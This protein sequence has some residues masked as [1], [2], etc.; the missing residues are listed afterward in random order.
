MLVRHRCIVTIIQWSLIA[1]VKFLRCSLI[2]HVVNAHILES[3]LL[4]NHCRYLKAPDF[5]ENFP[6]YP[7]Y[8]FES[9]NHVFFWKWGVNI[10]F[11]FNLVFNEIQNIFMSNIKQLCI[12]N[13]LFRNGQNESRF[14]YLYFSRV[15]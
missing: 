6:L 13:A 12:V 5:Y 1:H 9:C 7:V 4:K 2:G 10:I 14:I 15:L 11:I 8:N 3:Q